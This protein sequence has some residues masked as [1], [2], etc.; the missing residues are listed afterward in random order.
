MPDISPP[1]IEDLLRSAVEVLYGFR[2]QIPAH[3]REELRQEAALRV[4]RADGVRDPA[5]FVRSV[6]RHLAIDWLRRQREVPDSGCAEQAIDAT[7][8]HQPEERSSVRRL[9]CV[10]QSAPEP[11]RDLL[12][13]L[14][15]EDLEIDDLVASELHHRGQRPDDPGA[16]ST[17]RD[18]I[19]K[20]RHRAFGWVRAQLTTVRGRV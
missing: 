19:Y 1:A 3:V 4:L 17:A 14:F 15:F 6:T 16:R 10:L 2:H 12:L 7:W 8:R 9:A 13:G 20:R 5:R 11:Y 18:A